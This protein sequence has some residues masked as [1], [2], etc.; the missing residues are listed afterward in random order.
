[1]RKG[2]IAHACNIDQSNI[3]ELFKMVFVFICIDDGASKKLIFRE[4]EKAGIPFID[5]GMGL[6]LNKD[7]LALGGQIRVTAST[8][9]KRDHVKNRVSF[10]E[11]IGQ[12][13][14]NRNIQ[15][16]D[17]NAYNASLAVIKWKQIF[18]FYQDLEN[19]HTSIYTI[20]GNN[21]LNDDK[22]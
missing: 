10:S 16:A 14:Y 13:E 15:I 19:Q 6:Y 17:L 12:N 3:H 11:G 20:D 18:G 8:N 2:V 4:L 22:P 9:D 5:V 7:T 21:L 1:M